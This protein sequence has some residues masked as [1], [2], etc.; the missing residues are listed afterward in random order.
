MIKRDVVIIGAGS[1]GLAIAYYLS[2]QGVKDVT[3]LEKGYV[4]SG[5]TGRCGTGIRAQFADEPTIKMMKRSEENWNKLGEEIGFDFRQ[6]GYLYL[7]YTEEEIEQYRK[8]KKLQNSLGVPTEILSPAEAEELCNLI[9]TSEVKAASYNPEDGKAHPFE[10]TTG[11]KKYFQ[12][13]EVELKEQTEVNGIKLENGE[14]WKIVK[15]TGGNYRTKVLVNA[16]GGWAR[17]IGEMMGLDIP[18]TPYRHQ[19]IITE[20]FKPGRVEPMIISMRHED[21]YLT[22]TERGG[23]IGG[24]GTPEDEPP[25]YEMRETLSFEERVSKAFSSIVP[26][27]KHT[28]ILRHWAGYY[29]MS[30]DG[31]PML[32]EYKIPDHYLAVG[33]SGHGYMM[34]P[35]VGEGLAR[36]IVDRKTELPFDY[37]DPGRIDKGELRE[38]ALQMG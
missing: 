18:V 5:S 19:A 14:K 20:P 31:N 35:I 8:M 26:S 37:Y 21:A 7:L 23:I 2:K 12:E 33:F 16:A 4:G 32:G 22:Q 13:G 30:P 38:S 24:I 6:T 27:L 15:T 17:N 25:T 29:A 9:D 1:T 3:V 34:A 28:R 11:F 36:L 10:V